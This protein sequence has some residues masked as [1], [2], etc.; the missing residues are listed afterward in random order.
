MQLFLS[1]RWQA[2]EVLF[3]STVSHC[4]GSGDRCK[5]MSCGIKGIEKT[6][7]LHAHFFFLPVT[8]L[9]LVGFKACARY[10]AIKDVFQRLLW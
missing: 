8:A 5:K 7:T 6:F 10:T 3:Y 2:W 1:G 9:C 4:A